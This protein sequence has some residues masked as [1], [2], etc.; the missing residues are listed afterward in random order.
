MLHVHQLSIMVRKYRHFLF[1]F[2]PVVCV[3][4]GQGGVPLDLHSAVQQGVVQVTAWDIKR[5]IR[6]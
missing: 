2:Y 5:Q 1:T 3:H 4:V 6:Y